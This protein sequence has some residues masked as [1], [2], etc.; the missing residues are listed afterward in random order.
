[1]HANMLK[2]PIARNAAAEQLAQ[3][4]DPLCVAGNV[5][6]AGEDDLR[7]GPRPAAGSETSAVSCEAPKTKTELETGGSADGAQ[8]I[9]PVADG[10]SVR[11]NTDEQTQNDAQAAE[12][13]GFAYSAEERT[14]IDEANEALVP[15]IEAVDALE[16]IEAW[17]PPLVRG[18]RALRDRAVR[19]TRA[20]HLLD[21]Q[22]R[23][24]LGDL[25]NAEPI[26]PW[27]LDRHRLLN[28]V[29]YL[30]EDDSYLDIFT[31]WR[32]AIITDKQ[33]KTWRALPTLVDHFKHWQSG[34]VPSKDRRTSDQKAIERVRT[35]G[36]KADLAREAEVEEARHE[37][38]T[39]TIATTETLWTVLR[40]AGPGMVVQALRDQDA[41]DYA[42]SVYKL[43]GGWLKEPIT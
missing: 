27:L 17:V 39:Q 24:R 38:A 4:A 10:S 15:V 23:R 14:A 30:G 25:L 11:T 9:G 29:H 22:Y 26:G 5:L 41:K 20:L 3:T 33:R 42:R 37:L 6:E 12:P 40:Q 13:T 18:V 34:T 35:E 36:H 8:A 43:L 28:A 19:E 31:N 7:T 32:R 2:T 21:G 16:N 1:M